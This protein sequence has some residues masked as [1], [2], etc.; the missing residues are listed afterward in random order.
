MMIR[1]SF[2]HLTGEMIGHLALSFHIPLCPSV[3]RSR[4]VYHPASKKSAIRGPTHICSSQNDSNLSTWLLSPPPGSQ[5]K[6]LISM[7]PD[8]QSRLLPAL[9]LPVFPLRNTSLK[10]LP[11][12]F[13]TALRTRVQ[14]KVNKLKEQWNLVVCQL[15]MQLSSG[16]RNR[17]KFN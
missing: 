7:A 12:L 9:P 2:L 5:I 11:F 13:L 3:P 4:E 16:W 6:K 15:R 1:P 14:C 17:N 10:L 8:S